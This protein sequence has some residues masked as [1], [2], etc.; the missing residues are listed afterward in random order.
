M[1]RCLL[2][3]LLSNQLVNLLCV[4]LALAGL[5]DGTNDSAGDLLIARAVLF[6]DV[7]VCCQGVIDSL[8]NRRFLTSVL[9]DATIHVIV[10]VTSERKHSANCLTCQLGVQ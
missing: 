1:L 10:T 2:A 8:F 5:H 6:H 9:S 7:W 3:K 4:C